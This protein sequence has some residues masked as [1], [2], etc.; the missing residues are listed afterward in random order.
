MD[1]LTNSKLLAQHLVIQAGNDTRSWLAFHRLIPGRSGML[2]VKASFTTKKSE[3]QTELKR[4]LRRQTS[5][6]RLWKSRLNYQLSI[7]RLFRRKVSSTT[8]IFLR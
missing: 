6:E 3:A 2:G 8:A 1:N 7:S 5:A 4:S